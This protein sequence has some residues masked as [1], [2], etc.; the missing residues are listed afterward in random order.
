MSTER[1][2]I[3]LLT[4]DWFF[5]S[6]F[7]ARGRAA[8]EAG[9][10]V[11]L[12]A[13]ESEATARIRASGIEVIPV[14]FMRRR[15]NPFAELGFALQLARMYRQIRPDLVHHI[16]LKPIILGGLA[17]RLAGMKH[18]V[19]APV[20]LG[21]VFSSD[22]VLAK[23]LR[24]FVSL[25]L[26]L[27]LTPPGT[28]AIFE[29]PDDLN[30]MS[31]AGMV[32]PE[33]AVL[34]RGAG[35]DIETFAPAPEPE[36]PIRV[37]LI[38]RMIREKGVADFAAAARLL[39]GKAEFVLVGAPDPGNPDTVTEG[40]LRGWEEE[41][42]VTWLGPRRDIADLLRGAHIACQPSTFREGLPKSALEAMASG[43]PLVAT[44]IPGCR[45]TVVQDETGFL[46][47]PRDP[48]ALAAALERLIGDAALRARFGAAARRRAE[49]SF[50]D[51]VICAQTLSVYDALVPGR[52]PS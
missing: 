43:K 15:L 41:G 1:T 6:H 32:R 47:P 19:N 17:A 21:F 30:V 28:R 36:G 51:T 25:G 22:K 8:K 24:P 27:T 20:G 2:L 44:D 37:L 45:E 31:K 7:W 16:A 46:V 23:L 13:R 29:N 50:S 35:V 9:W 42:L 3:F 10:R 14:P 5:A 40:E 38:A 34:I 18:I 49:Q 12:I 48:A 33:A 52:S 26:K 39:K 4:E 11:I